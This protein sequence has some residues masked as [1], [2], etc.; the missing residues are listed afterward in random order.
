MLATPGHTKGSCCYY[1]E[2]EKL[3]IAGDT[4]FEGSCGRTDLPT[5]SASQISNSLK[6]IIMALPDDVDIY[7]GHGGSTTVGDER[8]YNPFC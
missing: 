4:I 6:N 5:G 7:P 1:F 3:L 2:N 8:K